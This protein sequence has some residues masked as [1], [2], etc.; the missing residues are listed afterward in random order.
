[1]ILWVYGSLQGPAASSC[2]LPA[3]GDSRRHFLDARGRFL[4]RRWTQTERERLE[5][6]LLGR[7]LL[8]TRCFYSSAQM[9]RNPS[10]REPCFPGVAPERVRSWRAKL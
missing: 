9:P 5:A 8:L 10:S 6:K 4:C 7:A 1:M 3:C 2:A